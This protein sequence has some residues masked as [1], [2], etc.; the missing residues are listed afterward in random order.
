MTNQYGARQP[1]ELTAADKSNFSAALREQA[2]FRIEQLVQLAEEETRGERPS[3]SLEVTAA[4]KRAAA[5]ALTEIES[6]LSRLGDGSYGTCVDC[7]WH[8]SRE[9]LEVLPAAALCM[10]CQRRVGKGHAREPVGVGGYERR[11]G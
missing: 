6:A 1:G 2:R 8:I 5:H 3:G 11:P 7:G 9:R 4:L 10:A